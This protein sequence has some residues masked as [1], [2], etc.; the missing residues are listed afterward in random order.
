MKIF[1][2]VVGLYTAF[3]LTASVVAGAPVAAA[4]DP[5]EEVTKEETTV[6]ETTTED[7]AGAADDGGAGAAGA[8]DA[9]GAEDA[10]GGAATADVGGVTKLEN[11]Q[12]L[13]KARGLS[14]TVLTKD[15]VK[16]GDNAGMKFDI[17]DK[18]PDGVLGRIAVPLADGKWAVPSNLPT[19]PST[20]VDKAAADDAI[21]RAQTFVAA[22]RDLKWNGQ[23]VTPLTTTDVIHDKMSKPYPIYCSS[24]VGMILKGWDYDHT[25]YVSDKNTSIGASM[26]FGGNGDRASE[27]ELWQ[28]N[29][30]AKW[31]Y[32][33][34]DLW[35][36]DG[37]QNY[38]RG[39][40]IF[41]SEQ[42]PEG[43]DSNTGS[44]FGN[45]FHVAIYAGDNKVIH[46]YSAD[47]DGGVVEQDI[48]EYL[49]EGTSFIARPSWN[50]ASGASS[51]STDDATKD[52]NS[53]GG[54]KC[55]TKGDEADKPCNQV[56]PGA[57][58]KLSF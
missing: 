39:D 34:G 3:L 22:G 10:G 15:H 26:D 13:K 57:E 41:L 47:S 4:S 45:I 18:Q 38:E 7:G 52:G 1:S 33:N 17:E 16:V 43:K 42:K 5:L 11:I 55:N 20:K 58:G 27:N 24:L 8:D 50:K 54:G 2:P 32:T 31:F 53:N 36:N 6:V 35:L 25:T 48:D 37:N 51:K 12:E 29:R 30:L 44:Y 14:G 23:G 49:R 46:S 19:A 40:L 28:S 9:R 21:S 56:T